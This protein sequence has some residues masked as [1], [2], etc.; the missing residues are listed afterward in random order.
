MMFRRSR[1]TKL[2]LLVCIKSSRQDHHSQYLAQLEQAT[3]DTQTCDIDSISNGCGQQTLSDATWPD[4]GTTVSVAVSRLCWSSFYVC[5]SLC[6][7]DHGLVLTWYCTH[8]SSFW[9]MATTFLKT[10][11]LLVG[12][13]GA[14]G[15]QEQQDV[16][17]RER[18][19]DAQLQQQYG[20]VPAR[21]TPSPS[22]P[23]V[24]ICCAWAAHRSL[25]S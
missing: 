13:C 10:E 9:V 6:V 3:C 1:P 16:C 8:A 25:N 7:C 11:D 5:V 24:M 15:K 21:A 23:S 2:T 18:N 4:V 12:F 20:V 14:G 22:L 19:S 17:A